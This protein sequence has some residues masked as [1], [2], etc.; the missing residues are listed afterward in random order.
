MSFVRVLARLALL[1]TKML[2]AGFRGLF[3]RLE[4]IAGLETGVEHTAD[5]GGQDQVEH[6][7]SM[8]D[9]PAIAASIRVVM[10]SCSLMN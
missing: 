7:V 4:L 8:V 10:W 5:H 9:Q 6:W 1:Q 2:E 3:Q